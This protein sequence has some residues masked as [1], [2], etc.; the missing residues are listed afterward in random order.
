M[1]QLTTPLLHIAERALD[2]ATARQAAIANNLANVDTPGY[3]TR[4]VNF[5]SE[6]QRQLAT[7]EGTPANLVVSRA[8]PGLLQRPDGN[9]VNVDREGL[10]LAQTQ[11]QFATAVQVIRSEFKRIR[12]AI[13][14]Q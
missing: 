5:E 6:L 3:Q 9:N 1:P 2:V 8:V 12:M 13:Q 14:E 4:D 7:P 11:L 10:L